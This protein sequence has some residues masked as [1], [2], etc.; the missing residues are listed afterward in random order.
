MLPAGQFGHVCRNGRER[1]AHRNLCLIRE[2]G[3]PK[4]VKIVWTR[5]RKPDFRG[6]DG[7]SH[8]VQAVI[9]TCIP[10]DVGE[11]GLAGR[12]L[13][14]RLDR[15]VEH[16]RPV[17]GHFDRVLAGRK[18][19]LSFLDAHRIVSASGP[20][21]CVCGRHRTRRDGPADG[22]PD[23]ADSG[24]VI[25]REGELLR[26]GARGCAKARPH[27][28]GRANSPTCSRCRHIDSC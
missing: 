28:R 20:L 12:K 4:R 10:P 14:V 23:G 9:A 27:R 26:D 13:G 5:R 17:A 8:R 19:E 6:R 11:R 1:R 18:I 7:R 24:A 22:L 21:V 2:F 15:D 16:L 25:R 3:V